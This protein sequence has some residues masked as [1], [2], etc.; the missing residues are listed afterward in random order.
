MTIAITNDSTTTEVAQRLFGALH[1]NGEIDENGASREVSELARFVPRLLALGPDKLVALAEEAEQGL[2]S[3]PELMT[4][5]SAQT[6]V[7]QS[8][9]LAAA[10]TTEPL[11]IGLDALGEVDVDM[12]DADQEPARC[13]YLGGLIAERGLTTLSGPGGSAKTWAIQSAC[14]DAAE[15]ADWESS[16]AVYLDLDGNGVTNLYSR[17]MLLGAPAEAIRRRA[18]NV[19]DPAQLAASE[20]ISTADA[21]SRVLR[22]LEQHPPKLVAID[23]M[24]KG[25]SAMGGEEN[26][27]AD[28]NKLFALVEVLRTLTSVVI[29]DHVGHET[30]DR[31][32]GASAKIDTP[33]N[34]I[35]LIPARKSKAGEGE[36]ATPPSLPEDVVA[37]GRLRAVKD[38][39]G[40][41][42]GHLG[43]HG[44]DSLGTLTVRRGEPW[45]VEVVSA[46]S[47]VK[48][49]AAAK[50][51]ERTA[52]TDS[53]T[54][55]RAEIARL[56]DES[57]PDGIAPTE[58]IEAL[59]SHA[60]AAIQ[61]SRT[62]ARAWVE[63]V[64]DEWT[65]AGR[66]RS[67]PFRRGTRVIGVDGAPGAAPEGFATV[68]ERAL[69]GFGPV[70]VAPA[71]AVEQSTTPRWP[72]PA[73]VG[74]AVQE[75]C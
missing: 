29:I 21:L 27:A 52:G 12:L 69:V 32:R 13:P 4:L 56:I 43:S 47:I 46:G 24:S 39:H 1:A 16:S 58:L 73:E 42:I 11:S 2:L 74:A 28:C 18:V 19:V 38:R 54:L 36:S 75:A 45:T 49:A 3:W 44:D 67:Q 61:M 17:L 34:V 22:G 25:L 55:R 70:A 71:P 10:T 60:D 59:A 6:G 63:E 7:R 62:R 72:E 9:V 20:Q 48:E 66:V 31:P 14:L 50:A 26:S 37:V 64:L 5:V 33:D 15:A 40:S 65:G 23:S 41:L 68:A 53:E 51:A 57:D 8:A 35:M 30:A